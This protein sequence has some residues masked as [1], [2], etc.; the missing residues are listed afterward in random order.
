MSSLNY[1][2]SD[3]L[4]SCQK[5]EW[6]TFLLQCEKPTTRAASFRKHGPDWPNMT[7]KHVHL[8]HYHTGKFF[9]THLPESLPILRS[10]VG[11]QKRNERYVF[12]Y[13]LLGLSPS[14]GSVG[15]PSMLDAAQRLPQRRFPHFRCPLE[16][17]LHHRISPQPTP[18]QTSFSPH[19]AAELLGRWAATRFPNPAGAHN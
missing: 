4:C 2:L 17:P 10:S 18:F 11:E 6:T 15:R 3:L 7:T 16:N 9:P 13:S 8:A 12:L 5:R 1:F 14:P 19:A